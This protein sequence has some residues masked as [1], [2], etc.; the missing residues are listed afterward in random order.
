M[1]YYPLWLDV[2]SW[3][4]T[5]SHGGP[6]RELSCSRT[7]SRYPWLG[8][9]TGQLSHDNAILRFRAEINT[10][11]ELLE[12]PRWDGSEMYP[13]RCGVKRLPCRDSRRNLACSILS[14]HTTAS[15]SHRN[16][17]PDASM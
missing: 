17:A 7:E 5:T 10:F 8:S 2:H 3:R 13:H 4:Q 15:H 11:F 9:T 12:R 6:A 1:D 14:P 16:M